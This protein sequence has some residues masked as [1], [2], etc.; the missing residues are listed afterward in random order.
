MRAFAYPAENAL[1]LKEP[2][3][4]MKYYLWMLSKESSKS[5]TRYIEFTN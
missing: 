4:L 2:S 3:S 5:D 1:V